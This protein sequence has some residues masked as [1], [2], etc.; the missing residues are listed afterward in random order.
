MI[1]VDLMTINKAIC[2]QEKSDSLLIFDDILDVN[3][4]LDP[5]VVYGSQWY[6]SWS[7][8]AGKN[9]YKENRTN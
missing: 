6:N 9:M 1:Q 3:V 4:S 8:K 2:A 7:S 5:S